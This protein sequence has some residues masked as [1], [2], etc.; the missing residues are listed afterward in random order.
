MKNNSAVLARS[1]RSAHDTGSNCLTPKDIEADTKKL[2]AHFNTESIESLPFLTGDTTAGVE[3]ELQAVV[4]GDRDNVDMPIHI[5]ESN[6]FKNIIAEAKSGNSPRQAITALETFLE[7]N[8]DN[9]WENSWVRFPRCHLNTYANEVF[10]RDLLHDKSEIFGP[11]RSDKDQFTFMVNG[12]EW[13]RI[14]I[15]YLLKLSLAD[16]IS[17]DE[18]DSKIMAIGNRLMNHF[19][20]DNTSPETFSFSPVRVIS[21][22]GMGKG[23]VDETLIRFALCQFLIQYANSR[24]K[25]IEHGQKALVY[26][27]PN[28]PTRQRQLN[29]LITDSF[30]RDLFMSPCLSGWNKGEEKKTYMALCHKVLSR[31]QLNAIFKLKEAG[32]LT[33]NLVTLPNTSN[34]SLANNGTHIS[35]GSK[36]LTDLLSDP[37]SG[38]GRENEKYI[39]D[40]VIKIVEHFLPLFV[41]TYSGAPYR[42]DFHNFHPERVL[43]F[44]PHELEAAHLKMI[45]RRWKNKADLKFMRQALTPF[46]PV[47]LDRSLAKLLGL[48]GDFLPDYRLVDYFVSLLSTEQS[49]ALNGMIGNDIRLKSDLA[50][51]GIFDNSMSVYLLCKLR[52]HSNMGFSGFECRYYSQFKDLQTDMTHAVNLQVL[53]VALAYQYVLRNKIT[54]H[55]I[56]NEPFIESERRQIFFSAAIGIPTVFIRKNSSNRFLLE[57]LKDVKRTRFSRR[58]EGYVR[59]HVYEY[60]MALIRKLKK[61][62]AAIISEMGIGETIYDLEQR[63][64]YPGEYGASGKLTKAILKKTGSR[65]PKKLGGAEFN[66]AAESYYRNELR[67]EN[68]GEAMNVLETEMG[69]MD[70]M[71]AWRQGDNNS[72]L[73]NILKGK[74]AA[75]FIRRAKDD[76]LR[77]RLPERTLTKMIQLT[78]MIIENNRKKKEQC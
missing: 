34:I 5:R 35:L 74:N 6:Y 9:V 48:R 59:V 17:Q 57:I 51:M 8:Q 55:D 28:P 44:L 23:I 31:S 53:I 70:S 47:W 16:I 58:Y 21:D 62:G 36:V 20:N 22:Y 7:S 29:E 61:D 68:L 43:G 63:L 18:T 49:P 64:N 60:L 52:E 78:L 2:L 76:T 24:F 40:L 10:E 33:R 42:L 3:N 30:Y 67:M 4:V 32:I 11:Q 26:F 73:M 27:A 65:S 12:E 37:Q 71:Q 41:S 15:S 56:P 25:L 75:E 14:P 13:I 1:T 69:V 38:F 72:T 46:G 39:G 77:E 66:T 19:L 45:W 54:H 50:S